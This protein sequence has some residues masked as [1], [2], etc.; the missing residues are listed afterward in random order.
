MCTQLRRSLAK[1]NPFT[2]EVGRQFLWAHR[3]S[4]LDYLIKWRLND[5]RAEGSAFHLWEMSLELAWITCARGQCAA[6]SL[7]FS[8][9]KYSCSVQ[10]NCSTTLTKERSHD[11]MEQDYYYLFYFFS[12]DIMLMP[13]ATEAVASFCSIFARTTPF[14]TL[15]SFVIYV[16]YNDSKKCV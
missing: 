6:F 5:R 10:F 9:F 13:L 1:I 12:E 14:K 16:L 2:I 11:T 15:F 4:L 8:V 7:R 3:G